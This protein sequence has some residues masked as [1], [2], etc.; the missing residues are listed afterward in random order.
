MLKI[1]LPFIYSITNR[2]T[3]FLVCSFEFVLSFPR[4]S[5]TQWVLPSYLATSNEPNVK[6]KNHLLVKWI[7]N[8][9]LITLNPIMILLVINSN[10]L[11]FESFPISSNIGK[12][13]TLIKRGQWSG[14]DCMLI[15]KGSLT[16]KILNCL[17]HSHLL[18]CALSSCAGVGVSAPNKKHAC[19]YRLFTDLVQ[20]KSL[21]STQVSQV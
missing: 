17:L 8:V 5:H 2:K 21:L 9:N 12:Q 7:K 6:I 15:T 3:K 13:K 10:S 16:L 19:F 20:Q 11:V 14:I 18:S 4:I 1:N